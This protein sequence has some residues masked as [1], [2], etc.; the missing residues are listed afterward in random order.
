MEERNRREAGSVTF[1][2]L[3]LDLNIS[4]KIT[5]FPQK[6]PE[7]KGSKMAFEGIHVQVKAIIFLS[8]LQWK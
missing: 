3:D 5:C 4:L 7:V 8:A 2:F 1:I 6:C